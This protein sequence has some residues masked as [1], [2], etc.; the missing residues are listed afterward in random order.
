MVPDGTTGCRAKNAVLASH[1]ASDAA[2][3]SAHEAAF[4]FGRAAQH[5]KRENGDGKNWDSH[6]GSRE[7]C[8]SRACPT[9][10]DTPR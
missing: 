3:R 10:L 4:G 1:M 8:V 5:G 6:G 9:C 7:V 2:D